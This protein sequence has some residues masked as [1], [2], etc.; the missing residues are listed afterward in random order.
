VPAR[1]AGVYLRG[2]LPDGERKSIEPPSRRATPPPDLSS[3]DPEQALQPFV[4]RSPWDEHQV[5]TRYRA[6]MAEP[7]GS[8]DGAF[9]IDDPSFP[10]RGRQSCGARGKRGKRATCPVAVAPHYSGPR[11]HFPSA[12]RP[13]R[14]ESRTDDAERTGAAGVPE[15]FRG[16]GTKGPIAPGLIDRARAEG[17]RGGPV[18]ADPGYGGAGVRDGRAARGFRH[19]AAMVLLAYGFL[20]RERARPRPEPTAREKRGR[21]NAADGPGDPP[22]LAAIAPTPAKH[23]CHYCRGEWSAP[24]TE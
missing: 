8:P 9:V 10:T 23:D 6:R 14:P 21:P 19:H 3:N 13:H 7:F 17:I 24:L 15:E 16:A 4:N 5:L 18:V 12:V 20:L 11:G 1:W 22:C 2:R